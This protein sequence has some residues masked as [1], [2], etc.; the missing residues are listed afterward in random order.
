MKVLIVSTNRE[1]TPFAVAPV[2]AAKI[3]GALRQSGHEVDFLDLCFAR[4][5]GRSLRQRIRRFCPDMIGLSIRNLDN[6]AYVH[7]HAYFQGDREIVRMIRSASRAPVIIGGSAVSVA[8]EELTAY[9][10]ADYAIAGEGENSLPAFLSAYTENSGFEGIP[11]LWWRE[12]GRWQANP[13]SFS[14]SLDDLPRQAYDCIDFDRY[15][16]AGGFV[17]MQT[18]RGC[19]F[20]CIY[21]SY[22]VLE[23]KRPRFFPAGACV[24]EMEKI[25]R[26]TGRSDFFFVDGVFN[27]PSGHATAVCEE[28]IRRRLKIR[29]LAYCNPSGL[30]RQMAA[31]FKA[32]GCAGIEL[33]LD[34]ATEKMLV[35]L[36]KGFTLS[37]IERTYQ[38]LSA[39]GLP[40]AVFLLFG[41]PGETV[42]D[43]EQ[44]Q[45]NLQGFGKA[46]AVFASLGLRIYTGTDL[47]DIACAEGALDPADSL[48]APRFYLSRH[49]QTESVVHRL[50]ML[51]RQDPT[52]STPTDWN[53]ATVKVIQWFLAKFRVIPCWKDIENYGAR[54][55]RQK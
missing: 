20:E 5:I 50:D 14:A 51:A 30:D 24:D 19:P 32:S 40:F 44:T 29:W 35:H 31:L 21:C 16:S 27:F 6:C 43:W 41:G 47:F 2:G 11:G 7:S 38:A 9:L 22:S 45:K 1:K 13:P 26:D 8:P 39:E 28:I 33:G 17:A 10:K 25:V 52:W 15:F 37:E 49:L 53:R 12:N 48:L 55:R 36:K 54:M 42:A 3:I 4:N 46:N 18:R 34:A 23:G